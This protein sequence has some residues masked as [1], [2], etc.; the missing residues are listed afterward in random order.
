MKKALAGFVVLGLLAGAG[1]AFAE[2]AAKLYGTKCAMCHG[3]EGKGNP[4]MSKKFGA[5]ALNLLDEAS[6]AK[7]G[8]QR[9]QADAGVQRTDQGRGRQSPGGVHPW[10][11]PEEITRG[12]R[13]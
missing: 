2:D 1:A 11:G 6:L 10:F 8:P 9:R 4:G 7:T 13:K 3:K 5:D 12:D